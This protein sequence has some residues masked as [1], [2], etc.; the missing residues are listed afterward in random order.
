[1][2][3]GSEN[4]E[5]KGNVWHEDC[6]TC[7]QCKKPIRSQSFMTKNDNV[8]CTPCHEK[9][10][11]KH[12]FS[13]KQVI[14]FQLTQLYIAVGLFAAVEKRYYGLHQ[15]MHALLIAFLSDC[16]CVLVLSQVKGMSSLAISYNTL[17]LT[18]PAGVVQIKLA[19]TPT[20]GIEANLT[21]IST[22]LQ[23]LSSF[24]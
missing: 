11:A 22:L 5:Y 3:V 10:F 6:F 17:G 16:V 19:I 14:H 13:C 20:V 12:C 9:K 4:V 23:V 24:V 8:Y 2:P 21:I 1:M 7:Y 18:H 15:D